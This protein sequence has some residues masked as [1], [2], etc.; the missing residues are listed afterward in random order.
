M[1]MVAVAAALT[2]CWAYQAS[3]KAE[4]SEQQAQFSDIS[5]HPYD[6]DSEQFKKYYETNDMVD[7][8][9]ILE[10]CKAYY[11]SGIYI[12]IDDTYAIYNDG[13]MTG[14]IPPEEE[15]ALLLEMTN[16]RSKKYVDPYRE[17]RCTIVKWQG[18]DKVKGLIF[19]SGYGTVGDGE[20]PD[21]YD[22][23]RLKETKKI[24]IRD[25]GDG[26]KKPKSSD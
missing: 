2:A 13:S 15:R 6:V 26:Q 14:K 8:F 7:G 22:D 1:A 21:I 11:D 4:P 17:Y 24:V 3:R 25:A 10:M 9:D 5:Y 23:I 12:R 20:D 19:S 16:P 18:S